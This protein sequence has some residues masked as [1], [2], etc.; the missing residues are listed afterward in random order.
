MIRIIEK[1]EL[2]EAIRKIRTNMQILKKMRIDP[3]PFEGA[4]EAIDEEGEI[5][6]RKKIREYIECGV[7][8]YDN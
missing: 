1:D 8:K 5:L 4:N 6:I 2:I 3:L 7:G